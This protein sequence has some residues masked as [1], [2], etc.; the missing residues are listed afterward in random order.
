[1]GGWCRVWSLLSLVAKHGSSTEV[2]Q[3]SGDYWGTRVLGSISI[4]RVILSF[5]TA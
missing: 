2:Y 5:S 1:M 4:P 3:V